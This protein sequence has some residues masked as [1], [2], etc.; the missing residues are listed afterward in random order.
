M[1]ALR[2]LSKDGLTFRQNLGITTPQVITEPSNDFRQFDLLRTNLGIVTPV[3][4]TT[5]IQDTYPI[6][7]NAFK[8]RTNLRDGSGGA[9][10]DPFASAVTLLLRGDGSNGSTTFTDSSS[11]ARSVTRNGNT[12]ISTAQSKYG[13]SS[14][15]FDGDNDWLQISYNVHTYTQN[16]TIECWLYPTVL[17]QQSIFDLTYFQLN[18]LRCFSDGSGA[19]VQQVVVNATVIRPSF[20]LNAWNHFAVSVFRNQYRV[21]TNG[22]QIGSPVTISP[23]LTTEGNVYVGTVNKGDFDFAGYIDSFRITEACRYFSN[24]NPET[25]TYLSY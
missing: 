14:I 9:I 25:D 12:V 19:G 24:F 22:I 15:Y 11:F 20:T 10:A 3:S 16:I 5:T 1:L 2:D 13:G 8:V 4:Q 23:L 21:F 18:G 6:N 7:F 17:T